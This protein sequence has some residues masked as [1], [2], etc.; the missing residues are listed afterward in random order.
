MKIVFFDDKGV[1][2]ETV[3]AQMPPDVAAALD[4]A[5]AWWNASFERDKG[6]DGGHVAAINDQGRVIRTTL[7]MPTPDPSDQ[8]IPV[9][10]G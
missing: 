4:G 9:R 8:R 3:L 2:A 6:S 1:L 5:R 7:P 10:A